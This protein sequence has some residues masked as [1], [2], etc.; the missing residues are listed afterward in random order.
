MIFLPPLQS[1]APPSDRGRCY[2]ERNTMHHEHRLRS[3][4]ST[5]NARRAEVVTAIGFAIFVLLLLAIAAQHG[6][7][8]GVAL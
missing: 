8:A 6:A 1:A 2:D 4:D 3:A 5:P 7:S